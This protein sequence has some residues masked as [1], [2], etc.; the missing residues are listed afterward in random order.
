MKIFGKT[1]SICSGIVP[2]FRPINDLKGGRY[3]P[4]RSPY[5]V[6]YHGNLTFGAG[7][8]I[9]SLD[10]IASIPGRAII[11]HTNIHIPRGCSVAGEIVQCRLTSTQADLEGPEPVQAGG[12]QQVGVVVEP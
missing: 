1:F 2:L 5:H 11:E 12:V 3:T 9:P 4:L 6:V 8:I 10:R 7:A